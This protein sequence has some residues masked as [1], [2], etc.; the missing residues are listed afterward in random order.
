MLLS[1]V[2][3]NLHPDGKGTPVASGI[4]TWGYRRLMQKV[5][6]TSSKCNERH[7]FHSSILKGEDL[8][9]EC[10]PS[11]EYGEES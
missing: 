2:T 7:N 9:S 10:S 1:E 6:I 11:P 3:R 8:G 5:G 4:P